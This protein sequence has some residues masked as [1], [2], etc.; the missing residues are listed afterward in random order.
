ML[1]VDQLV[2]ETIAGVPGAWQALQAAV[3]PTIVAIARRHATLRRKG[4][5]NLPDDVAEVCTATLERLAQHTFRNLREYV[6]R[7]ELGRTESFDSW[8]YGAVDFVIRDHLR[9]RFGR[10]PQEDAKDVPRPSKRDLQTGADRLDAVMDR[11]Y[12]STLS[13]ASKATVA[14]ILEHVAQSFTVAEAAALRMY[15]L[16][17]KSFAELAEALA[18]ESPSAAEQLIRRVVARLRYRFAP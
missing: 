17:G 8:L 14:Q 2:G 4:L 18:L 15:Y 12:L 1:D 5:A 13:L 6:A 9:A 3:Q 11:A 7:R 16:E 10:A